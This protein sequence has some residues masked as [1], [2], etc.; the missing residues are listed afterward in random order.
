MDFQ[1]LIDLLHSNSSAHSVILLCLAIF[2]GLWLGDRSFFGAKFGIAGVLFSGLAVGILGLPTDSHTL[3]FI[4]EFGLILYVFATGLQVGRGFFASLR[5]QGFVLNAVALLIVVSGTGLAMLSKWIFNLPVESSVGILAGAVTNTPSLGAAQQALKSS[6]GEAAANQAGTGYA[7]AYPCAVFSIIMSLYLIRRL[8]RVSLE[9]EVAKLNAAQEDTPDTPTS[10]SLCVQNPMLAGLSIAELCNVV[11]VPVVFSRIQ[12]EGELHVP[13]DQDLIQLGDHL[14]ADCSKRDVE[15]IIRFIGHRDGDELR[16]QPSSLTVR[17]ILISKLP[18]HRKLGQM[19]LIERFHVRVTRIFRSGIALMPDAHTSLHIGD[20][21]NAV[22]EP[23]ELAKLAQE[24]GDR[25]SALDHPRLMPIFLGILLGV[26]VGSL[27]IHFPGLPL[28]LK[29]GLA[30][31]PM[32]VALFMGFIRQIGPLT[33]YMSTGSNLMLR[34]F[35]IILFLASVGIASGPS[36]FNAII[37]PNGWQWALLALGI[38]FI[39]VFS[40]GIFLRLKHMNYLSICGVLAGSM[41]SSPA[42]GYSNSLIESPAQ[43]I[44]YASVYPFTMFLRVIASQVFVMALL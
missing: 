40:V 39:P 4:R 16:R 12:H 36:F 34:E 17:R 5:D 32:L 19:R 41:T 37:S 29:L 9:D 24:V 28:P 22:G 26:L 33:F 15:R 43:S 2:P 38:N 42:L 25:A 13:G 20:F 8:F 18:K 35:G 3:D 10:I 11:G 1:W 44:G 23:Q 21:L 27:P 14:Q 30:G 31:G 6:L 7:V